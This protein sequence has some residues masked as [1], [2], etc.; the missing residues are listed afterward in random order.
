ME[1]IDEEAEQA[2][3]AAEQE[4]EPEPEEQLPPEPPKPLTA[5][6]EE[7]AAALKKFE[8]R[9][10]EVESTEKRLAEA[11][12]EEEDVLNGS[13]LS[14]EHAHARDHAG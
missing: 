5:A 13:T 8:A 12:T 1:L 7:L 9:V 14:G 4:S 2:A 11:A 6:K 3:Q 10:G